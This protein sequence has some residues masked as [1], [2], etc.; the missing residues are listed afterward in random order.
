MLH[1][2][3]NMKPLELASVNQGVK[4]HY[5]VGNEMLELRE[6]LFCDKMSV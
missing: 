4:L 1:S 6:T 3:V 2:G 5:N